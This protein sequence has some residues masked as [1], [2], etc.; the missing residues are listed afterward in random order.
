MTPWRKSSHSSPGNCVEARILSNRFEVR[1]SK[2][3]ESSE[4]LCMSKND[5]ESFLNQVRN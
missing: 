2:L 1:D 4:I 3:G 5:W